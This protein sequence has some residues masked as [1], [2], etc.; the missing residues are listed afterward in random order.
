[1]DNRDIF[2]FDFVDRKKQQ[3]IIDIFL[4]DSSNE[5]YLW[6]NGESGIGKSFFIEKRV[7]THID[8]FTHINVCLSSE[9]DNINCINE[10][11]QKLQYHFKMDFITFLQENYYSILDIG[12]KSVLELIKINN[13]SFAWF[14]DILFNSDII[15]K[16]NKKNTLSG[17]KV[18]QN[19]IDKI[20]R[21]NKLLLVIDNFTN[22]DQKSLAILKSIFPQYINNS[23]FKCIFITTSSI[24]SE[25]EYIEKFLLESLPINKMPFK[26]LDKVKYFFSI[27][28]NLFDINEDIYDSM[29]SIYNICKGNPETLKSLI[30]KIYINDGINIPK[31]EHSKAQIKKDVLK[32]YLIEKSFDI[33]NNDLSEDERFVIQIFLGFGTPVK[34][35][36]LQSCIL[37][38]HQRMFNSNLWTISIVNNILSSLQRKNILENNQKIEFVHDRIFWGLSL[39][40]DRDL[41][42]PLI[43]LY[44]HEYLLD[45]L[46]T[47]IDTEYL[48]AYHSYIA[49]TNDWINENYQFGLKK[50]NSKKYSDAVTIFNRL[51]NRNVCLN[52]AQMIVICNALYEMGYYHES[53]SLLNQTNFSNENEETLFSY[54]YLLGKIENVLLNKKDALIKYDEALKFASNRETEIQILNLKHLA[55]LETPDGKEKARDIFNSIAL[56]LSDEEKKMMSV[57]NLLRNCNQFYT[58][59][60]A[61]EFFCLAKDIATDQEAFIDVAYVDNNYGLELFRTGNKESAFEQ[62]S[63]S[64]KTLRDLKYHEAAY[65]LNN[66]AVYEMF[67]TNYSDALEYLLEAKY[68][69][70]SLYADLAI[71]MHMMIC[72]REIKDEKNCRRYMKKLEDYLFYQKIFDYNIIRKL[73]INLCITYLYYNEPISANACLS[74]GLP[75]FSGTISEYRGYMLDKKL[76]DTNHSMVNAL[77]SN[78]YYTTLRF[79]PWI[80]TLSHD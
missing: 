42:K 35:N 13:I 43:S 9:T 41:N 54:N 11:I 60:K 63:N 65:P 53:K 45:N 78:D 23:R 73:S 27:L 70:Q 48:L 52:C 31:S 17:V 24:L 14:F 6:M 7:D 15:F 64:Y 37:Y 36:I 8:N 32:K 44:F 59:E 29:D 18:I 57:C 12:K 62:F 76:N 16:D 20:L 38:I 34:L 69:N 61:K 50:Y 56:H 80:I 2:Q 21:N 68:V 72:Y 39:L 28:D 46:D 47:E 79:E 71:K 55:L 40:L 3:E 26:K 74:K 5:N 67:K 10:I 19:Y 51:I 66:M 25:R 30:R 58:G 77:K 22:C 4:S 33:D 49:Q 1:M 75:Y